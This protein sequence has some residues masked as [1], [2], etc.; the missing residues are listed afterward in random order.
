MKKRY[1]KARWIDTRLAKPYKSRKFWHGFLMRT[2]LASTAACYASQI[3]AVSSTH[4]N[5]INK[6]WAAA[7][8][9]RSAMAKMNKIMAEAKQTEP[10]Q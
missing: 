7:E 6:A 5:P 3:A 8:I 10:K 1:G 9:V 2:R 4:G